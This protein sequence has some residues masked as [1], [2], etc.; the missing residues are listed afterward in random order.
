VKTD[1]PDLEVKANSL[2]IGVM[3]TQSSIERHKFLGDQTNWI[4]LINEHP[5]INIDCGNLDQHQ[6]QLI[7]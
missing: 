1:A 4:E 5:I 6:L 2:Q 7:L 3:R